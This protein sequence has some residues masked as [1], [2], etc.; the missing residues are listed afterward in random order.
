MLVIN[1]YFTNGTTHPF[2]LV[3]W[4]R[5][6]AVIQGE[7]SVVFEQKGVEFPKFWSQLATNVVAQKYFRGALG[8]PEREYSLRQLIERVTKTI[9]TE[10]EKRG[11]FDHA[12]AVVF[13]RE[14][15]HL[16][17]HQKMAFNSPVWF[18]VG[19]EPQPQCSA[20]FI[21]SVEDTMESILTLAKTEGMLFKYGS[22]TGT[23]LSP[24]RSS[25][26]PLKGGGSASGPVSFMRGFDAFAGVIKS[27][28]KTRRAAKMV[29]LNCDHPDI[30]QFIACKAHEEK[31]AHALIDAGYDGSFNGEAYNSVF[32]QNSNN[33][34]R[35]T[36]EFMN[37][38]CQG[39]QY[40]LKGRD[41][42]VIETVNARD[43]WREI[44]EAAWQC[45]DPGVQFDS[46]CNEW[47]TSP[48]SGRI[49]ASNPCQPDFATV[50]TPHG[51]RTFADIQVGSIIWSGQQWTKVTKKV[52]TGTK[53]VW[54]YRTNAGSFIGTAQHR[55]IQ[56]GQRCEA[57]DATAIDNCVGQNLLTNA[58]V[59]PTSLQAMMDGWVIGDGSVHHASG[60]LVYLDI[61]DED[62]DIFADLG[63]LIVKKRGIG[64]YSYEVKT[65]IT[66]DELARTYE[67][68]IPH[69]YLTGGQ[70]AIASF[71]RGLYSANGSIC[72]GRVTLKA[73]SFNIISDVQQ[74]LSALGIA[75]YVTTNKAVKVQFSNGEY[76]CK[77]SY[78][79]NITHGRML[80]RDL[81]GFCQKHKQVRLNDA[82][83][84]KPISKKK[85]TWDIVDREE[86]GQ[87]PVYDITVEA[88]EHTY[89]TGG[90]LVSNCSEY[91]Y[92]DDSACNLASLNL[93]K[94]TL[95]GSRSFDIRSFTE[96]VYLTILAQEIIVGFSSYPTKRIEEN[97]HRFRPLGL[98]Y[99][100]LGALLMSWGIPY[101]SDEGRSYAAGITALMTGCAYR[102]SA[103]IARACGGP[104]AGFA[105]NRE[106]FLAVIQKHR[107]ACNELIG[108]NEI[109]R[110]AL[111]QWDMA[112]MIGLT[113]GYRNSQATVLAPTGTIGFMMDCDTTGVEPDIA[114]VKY[115]RLVGG[116]ML[117]I[118]NQTV[119]EA[120]RVL[121]YADAQREKIVEFIENN[122][123]IEGSAIAPE[124][125]PV[126][127][128]AFRA[129]KGTRSIQPIGHIKMMA[130]V[131]P[132]L[133]GAIS[134]TVNMPSDATVEDIAEIYMLAWKLRLKAVAIYRDGCKR[135]Q[136]LSTSSGSGG[137]APAP[138]ATATPGPIRRKLPDERR[139]ITHKFVI[140][141]HEGYIHVGL[142]PDGAPGE[143]FI[144]M[145]KEGSTISGLM[146]SF[147][148]AVSLGLQ[149][150]VPLRSIVD[151]F[152][153][154]RFEPSGW[155]GHEDIGH[156]SS[157]LDY[158]ARW[159][160]LKFLTEGS[161]A[162]RQSQDVGQ[163]QQ[164]QQPRAERATQAVIE[165][166]APLCHECGTVM[167]RSGACHKCSNCG[168]T[169]GC[170]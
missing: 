48:V 152:S 21:N 77:Q 142:Y 159:L 11:Y 90:L 148:T 50:L 121:G 37:A 69:R 54:R 34:V 163:V 62:H 153:R 99:A 19:V 53:S 57:Q 20:C 134:K 9:A 119:N 135:I 49:N 156:A 123:T 85:K 104:C 70:A 59:C 140:G 132:F 154:T 39:V 14:L 168:A 76:L 144:T 149:Y 117:K 74:M 81:I 84:Q 63:C 112:H 155:S 115:K 127:D 128:C 42:S 29:I 129:E 165:N 8:T 16:I 12:S 120:L 72:G 136:P 167:V 102:M 107:G 151:K 5:R 35:V 25:R 10:G 24:L 88:P 91:M 150:G 161:Q 27:G 40:P 108:Q 31:K 30:R 80:F 130:A 75:S 78:D 43:I 65:T 143:L 110:A 113:H 82:C 98:G 71:L 125:L 162:A 52:H 95:P 89:W 13:E 73:A 44:A 38:V 87:F 22:G 105:E 56:N 109:K 122:D 103:E 111:W 68:K 100:N 146:D 3:E 47:H 116:G 96:A 6:D 28:G 83:Q 166:D 1:P 2:D 15:A 7:G 46:V 160:E 157:V 93:R 106:P 45:G 55:V 41:G 169:S 139:S 133:S 145:S 4:E 61:G 141:N 26:E 92:L 79:L 64:P 58:A 32:F 114:L 66:A 118:T 17:L 131:Q 158:I 86:L 170:S 164:P 147:A 23:N 126:F 36:D 18:N 97:S 33:S 67:R 60:D 137:V 51:I 124:H 101:D 94:F 138:V